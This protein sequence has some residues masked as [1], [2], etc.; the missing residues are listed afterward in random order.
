MMEVQTQLCPPIL[1]HT[2]LPDCKQWQRLTTLSL[3]LLKGIPHKNASWLGNVADLRTC[4]FGDFM[5]WFVNVY[6][7]EV[8]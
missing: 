6:A 7:T 4:P 8:V 5:Y 3:Q 1:R 2:A